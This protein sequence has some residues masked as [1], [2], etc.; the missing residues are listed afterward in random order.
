M[1]LSPIGDISKL[2]KNSQKQT[3]AE[4]EAAEINEIAENIFKEVFGEEQSHHAKPLYLKNRTLTVTCSSP[5]IAQ[6]IRE[7]QKNI[8]QKINDKLG[9]NEVDRIRYLA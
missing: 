3:E 5:D 9:K 6:E 2:K 8:V 4:L 1:S 7:N